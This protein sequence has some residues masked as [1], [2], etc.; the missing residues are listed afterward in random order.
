[1]Q[2][3]L[4]DLRFALRQ[5]RTSSGFAALAVL[6]L[7]FWIG[8]NTAMFTVVE[9]VFARPLQYPHAERLVYVGPKDAKGPASTAWLNLRDIR[10]RSRVL[11]AVGGFSEDIGVVQVSE[12]I[13]VCR[14]E[15]ARSVSPRPASLPIS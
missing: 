14:E 4:L 10:D 7:A 8:P 6:T 5:L 13:G 3:F 1:M 11:D 12:D 2:S 9:S 15:M